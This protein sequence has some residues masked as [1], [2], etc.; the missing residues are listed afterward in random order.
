M[1]DNELAK[2]VELKDYE[3]QRKSKINKEQNTKSKKVYHHRK[4]K[5]RFIM[6]GVHDIPEINKF[7]IIIVF[8]IVIVSYLTNIIRY[9]I[10]PL[11]IVIVVLLFISISGVKKLFMSKTPGKLRC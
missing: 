9:V 5:K 4:H 10:K 11:L 2:L 1:D 8:L 3:Q 7:I 6:H